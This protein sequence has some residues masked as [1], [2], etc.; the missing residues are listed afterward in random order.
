V[1]FNPAGSGATRRWIAES[2]QYVSVKLNGT[3][4]TRTTIARV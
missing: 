1:R 2:C 3:S 4:K